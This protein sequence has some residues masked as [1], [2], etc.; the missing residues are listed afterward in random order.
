M[1]EDER[2]DFRCVDC[3]EIAEPVFEPQALKMH[4]F[5]EKCQKGLISRRLTKEETIAFH[6]GRAEEAFR[7]AYPKDLKIDD[8]MTKR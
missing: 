5:C 4:Y 8:K 2:T 6:L 1:D 7:K 3:G